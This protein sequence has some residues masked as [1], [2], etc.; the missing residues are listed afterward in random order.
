[1]RA[2]DEEEEAHHHDNNSNDMMMMQQQQPHRPL[3]PMGLLLV[4][5]AALLHLHICAMV[6]STRPLDTFAPL[7]TAYAAALLLLAAC[8]IV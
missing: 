6:A 1:V 5:L 7:Y 2:A 3:A 4:C 8:S